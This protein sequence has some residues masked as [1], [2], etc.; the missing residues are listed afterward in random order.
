[1][2]FTIE[3]PCLSPRQESDLRLSCAKI[4]Q[5]SAPS[6]S[7][8]TDLLNHHER[9]QK[10]IEERSAQKDTSKGRGQ[11]PELDSSHYVRRSQREA[12]NAELPSHERV[13]LNPAAAYKASS[14]RES[15]VNKLTTFEPLE[16][17]HTTTSGQ[18]RPRQASSD[19]PLTK[20]RLTLDTRPKTSAAACIDYTGPSTGTSTSTTRTNTT[21]ADRHPSTGLTSLAL[22]PADRKSASSCHQRVSEQVLRDNQ[23]ASIADAQAKA[24]MA[25]ELA[26]RRENSFTSNHLYRA[27]SQQSLHQPQSEPIERPQSRTGSITTSIREYIRPRPSSD[28][29]K[30]SCSEG[31]ASRSSSRNGSTNRGGSWWRAG[32]ALRR[33]GSWN[34]F[35][36]VKPE[37]DD[38]PST[39]SGLDLNRS[40]PPLP[41]LDQYKER[42]PQPMHISQLMAPGRS[43]NVS[44]TRNDSRFSQIPGTRIDTDGLRRTDSA[45][46][47]RQRELQML[48]DEKMRLGAIS[49]PQSPRT[50]QL[51][52][53][54]QMH[55]HS[56]NA[57]I[58]TRSVDIEKCEIVLEEP[59]SEP[60]VDVVRP[61]EEQGEKE[62]AVTVLEISKP[63]EKKLGLRK[64]LSRFFHMNGEQGRRERGPVVAA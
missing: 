40:L 43:S 31:G 45:I 12:P 61:D 64:R 19:D 29:I 47:R 14:R 63:A 15:H 41:G 58:S 23:A 6:G 4:A 8:Y 34:S 52:P 36:S 18:S 7:E 22:T 46:N 26:R 48:V 33:K 60:R 16:P 28:S 21:Y 49:P 13:P 42:K 44:G 39:P 62:S 38:Q 32:S 20:I 5:E 57:S 17:T 55:S 37:E 53:P 1:M 30:S 59:I 2:S 51:P 24:W 10:Y 25:Q 35:R 11:R 9:L 50:S 56:Q 3:R 27:P 54:R